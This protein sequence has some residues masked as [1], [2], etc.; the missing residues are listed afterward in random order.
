MKRGL[1]SGPGYLWAGMKY[2]KQPG[3]RRYVWLPLLFNIL[4]FGAGISWAAGLV[5]GWMTSL[6]GY[7]PNWL[8]FMQ[9]L[10]WFAFALLVAVLVAVGFGV[11]AAILAAP[12][13]SLLSLAVERAEGRAQAEEGLPWWRELVRVLT[14]E[15][16][17][18]GYYLPRAVLLLVAGLVPVTAPFAPA[19]WFVFGA[20]MMAIQYLDYPMDNHQ[21][22]FAEMKR[23]L[24]SKR[25]QTVGFGM[26][27]LLALMV[28]ILN[29]VVMPA[30]VVGATLLCLDQHSDVLTKC[31]GKE[32]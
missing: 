3:V 29:L 9:G 25:M 18:L 17:K 14:R 28:P 13:N 2:L 19:L 7:L 23:Q 10:L 22:S 8:G 12:F 11:L 21:V 24:A 32:S 16:A 1:W 31:S 15:L 4:L 6:M 5:E 30:A 20:W 27:V 26:A